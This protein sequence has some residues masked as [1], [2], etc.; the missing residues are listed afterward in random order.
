MQLA[1]P[2]QATVLSVLILRIANSVNPAAEENKTM[3]QSSCKL[4][5]LLPG[6]Q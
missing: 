6:F 3:N 5:T 4:V 1:A 2:R